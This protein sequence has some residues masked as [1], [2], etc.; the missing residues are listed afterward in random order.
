MK[1]LEFHDASSIAEHMI[2]TASDG[3]NVVAVL[4]FDDAATLMRELISCQDIDLGCIE[5]MMQEYNGYNRE[6]Y[7]SLSSDGIMSVERA[8]D[9]NRYLDPEPD[10]MILDCKADIRIK[11]KIPENC[12]FEIESIINR[13]D[14]DDKCITCCKDCTNC[15]ISNQYDD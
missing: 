13:S 11:E 12:C 9:H 1:R 3:L 5:I 6:Y 10:V 15:D 7:V 8:W 2:K 14:K 4:F